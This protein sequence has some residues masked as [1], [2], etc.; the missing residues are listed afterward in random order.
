V[1]QLTR[2]L[3]LEWARENVRVNAVGM[4][5]MEMDIEVGQKDPILN[6]GSSEY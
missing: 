4:G 2:A 6:Y 5:W 1:I 3:A